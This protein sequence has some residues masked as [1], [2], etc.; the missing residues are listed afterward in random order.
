MAKKKA[1]GHRCVDGL[2]P[3]FFFLFVL[4]LRD[5][6]AEGMDGKLHARGSTIFFRKYDFQR[7]G[8]C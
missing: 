6:R 5:G 2:L 4:F 3:F 7:L 1:S 8:L